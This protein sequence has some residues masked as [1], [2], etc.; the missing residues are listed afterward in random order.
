M[1][2]YNYNCINNT[3]FYE[4]VFNIIL[5]IQNTIYLNNEKQEEKARI[6]HKNAS[7]SSKRPN[8]RN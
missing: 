3:Y 2:Y 7:Y 6:P 8:R 5:P 4:D 1:R